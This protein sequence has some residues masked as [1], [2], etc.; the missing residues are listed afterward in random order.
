MTL[1]TVDVLKGLT[2]TR[3]QG[4]NYN[5]GGFNTYP[6][7]NGYASDIGEGD[8]VQ[9]TGGEIELATNALAVIGVFKGCRYIDSNGQLQYKTNF[10]AG[11]S[12]Q[13]GKEVEG[14]YSQPLANVVDDKD[15]SYVVR[16]QVSALA[17][18]A[19]GT[20]YKMS[21]I[22]SVVGG[23][24]QA[25]LDVAASAGTSGGHMVT[26]LGL[27]TGR[28]SEW[29]TGPIAVEVKLSNHGIVGEL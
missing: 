21:A 29:G 11:V 25:V 26:V 20:S 19:I 4:A 9:L 16:T 24:S 17:V 5:S 23:R 1:T 18:T 14:G 15:Q 28:N 12:S 7:A 3:K 22:G 2:P 13:G 6:I 8:P 27:W 10:T